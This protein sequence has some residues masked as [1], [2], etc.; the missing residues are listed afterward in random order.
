VLGGTILS[1]GKISVPG[2]VLGAALLAMIANALVIVGVSQYW[3]QTG[4]G[5]I[6][7]GAAGLDQ[8]R[9][10]FLTAGRL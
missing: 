1:G 5:L 4:L 3:Y 8:V 2:T 9:L 10:R 6:I 7:L